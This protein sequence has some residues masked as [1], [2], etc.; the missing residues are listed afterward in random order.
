M[1]SNSA[2][3]VST[4]SN[5]LSL[6]SISSISTT[7]CDDRTCSTAKC[8]LCLHCSQQYCFV[9]FLKHNEQLS[10]NAYNFTL[11]IDQLEDQIKNLKLDES[12][13]RTIHSLDQWRK[14]LI[15]TIEYVYQEKLSSIKSNYIQLSNY[16]QQFQFEQSSHIQALRI[17]LEQMKFI[18]STYDQEMEKIQATIKQLQ[19]NFSELQYD[20]HLKERQTPNIYDSIECEIIWK[21]HRTDDIQTSTIV[22]GS[23]DDED[24]NHDDEDVP[25]Y[26]TTGTPPPSTPSPTSYEHCL[27]S[28]LVG[29]DSITNKDEKIIS[30]DIKKILP[31]KKNLLMEKKQTNNTTST[32]TTMLNNNNKK[33]RICMSC[34]KCYHPSSLQRHY[35]QCKR[36]SAF[37]QLNSSNSNSKLVDETTLKTVTNMINQQ[38]NLVDS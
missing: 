31:N 18:R 9:H 19:K 25:D 26:S 15:R 28:F 27:L 17:D 22:D 2:S 24:T 10:L 35:R 14:N 23:E 37:R 32:I 36:Q 5:G 11:A 13:R 7:A 3:P 8:A 4:E 34:G 30:S 1:S 29:N 38:Q 6:S 20:L 16:L 12:L 33:R 21:R